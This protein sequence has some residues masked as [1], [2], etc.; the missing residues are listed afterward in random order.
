[1][2]SILFPKIIVHFHSVELWS[3]DVHAARRLWTILHYQPQYT[4]YLT[5]RHYR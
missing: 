1:M 5:N 2:D 4:F 3:E